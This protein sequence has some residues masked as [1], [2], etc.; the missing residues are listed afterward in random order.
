MDHMVLLNLIDQLCIA[1]RLN[2]LEDC[3]SKRL[4]THIYSLVDF[5]I[6]KCK[7]RFCF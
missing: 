3:P 2:E 7:I 4:K 1:G 5:L 6:V